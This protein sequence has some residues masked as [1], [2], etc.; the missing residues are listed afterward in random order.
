MRRGL[1][2]QPNSAQLL[3]RGPL[4]ILKHEGSCHVV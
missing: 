3:L 4:K 2:N 1:K